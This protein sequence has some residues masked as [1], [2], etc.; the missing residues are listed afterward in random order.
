VWTD[1][2]A[3]AFLNR[4]AAETAGMANVRA[5]IVPSLLYRYRSLTRSGTGLAE[6]IDSIKRK[7]LYCSEFSRMNDPM[8]GFFRPSRL[9]KGEADYRKIVRDITDT[10]STVGIACFSETYDSIL[11]WSHYAGNY[12][13]ICIG[14]STRVLLKGLP[15]DASLVRLAYIDEP[16]LLVSSHVSDAGDAAIRILSQKQY[17]WAYEREW[18]VLGNIGAVYYGRKEAIREI[19][20]GSRVDPDHKAQVLSAIR[21]TSIKAY[22][23]EIDGY[24]HSWEEIDVLR[25]AKKIKTK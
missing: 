16:P 1:L 17:N 12:S 14:Y 23:M 22:M 11:M 10:K 6:E 20:L 8:E 7:Y 13:G 19:S 18:R 3:T 2:A 25:K 24:G 21:G 4:G 5:P 15:D 9:L